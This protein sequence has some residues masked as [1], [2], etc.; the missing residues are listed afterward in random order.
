MNNRIPPLTDRNDFAEVAE[1]YFKKTNKAI[2]IGVF[3]GLF[4]RSNL[5]YWSGEYYMC[6]T[7][8]MKRP[9]DAK[10]DQELKR[11]TDKNG[12]QGLRKVLEN[13]DS[14][15]DRCHIVKDFSVQAAKQFEDNFFDW[16]YID[17]MHDYTNVA[18]DLEAWWP[19]LRVGGLFSGDDFWSSQKTL[20]EYQNRDAE[21]TLSA[22]DLEILNRFIVNADPFP[23]RKAFNYPR[24]AQAFG[25]GTAHAVYEHAKKTGRDLNI[26]FVNDRYGTP[27]WYIIK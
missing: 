21:K 12:H 19:K 2:E 6:D 20:K 1:K 24:T 8:D 9:E 4:A 13:T 23:Q 17:A 5:K 3:E 7:F 22:I 26:T 25:W 10:R 18:N 15:K 11:S 27:A 16:I 14:A